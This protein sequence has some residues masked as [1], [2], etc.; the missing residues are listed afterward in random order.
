MNGVDLKLFRFDGDLTWM[1]FF[2]DA[3]NRFYTRY[4]GRNDSGAESHLNRESLI[5]LMD[6]VIRIQIPGVLAKDRH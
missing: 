4:G 6:G 2:M 1:S 5:R 3:H